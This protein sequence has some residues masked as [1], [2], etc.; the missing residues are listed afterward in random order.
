MS[1]KAVVSVLHHS[2]PNPNPT[3]IAEEE[4]IGWHFRSAKALKA[5]G[6]LTTIC[7]RPSGGKQW[8]NKVVDDTRVILTPTTRLS[9]NDKLWKWSEISLPMANYVTKLVTNDGCIPY[10]HEYRSLNSE[11]IIRKLIEYPMI[12][13]HHGSGPPARSELIGKNMLSSVREFARFNREKLFKKVRGA[14]FVLNEAEKKYFEGLGAEAMVRVRTMGADFEELKPVAEEQKIELRKDLEISEDAM[15]LCSYL[16]V[17][18]EG[19]SEMKGA[20]LLAKIW[21]A[22]RTRVERPLLII[23]TGLGIHWTEKLRS[24]G[25]TAYRFLPHNQYL[26]LLKASDIYFLPATSGYYGVS[27]SVAMMEALALGKPV[28]SSALMHFPEKEKIRYI[29]AATPFVDNENALGIFIERLAYVIENLSLFRAEYIRQIGSK[30]YS[31]ES[32]VKVFEEVF[33][34]MRS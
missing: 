4:N 28:V 21:N 12:L 8:V 6:G 7:V 20:H 10:V 13:Q 17:F 34:G 24:L 2:I 19:F 5:Y 1:R 9:V 16:G 15:V 18:G 33:K 27:G 14:I 32:F 11:I 31:W 23:A 26:E 3:R 30:Y 25:I 29:G 22:L